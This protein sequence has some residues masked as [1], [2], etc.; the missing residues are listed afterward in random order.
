MNNIVPSSKNL[1]MAAALAL[2]LA[3]AAF[4]QS[5]NVAVPNPAD[6]KAAG[7]LG[8]NYVTTG[9]SYT[10]LDNTGTHVSDFTLTLNENLRD[11][12]DGIVE[13]GYGRSSKIAGSRITQHDILFGARAF[14]TSGAT[15]PYVEAGVGWVWQ[16]GFGSSDDSFA[17]G[18]GVGAE[19][20]IAP[21]ATLTPFVR[22]EDITRGS[23]NDSWTYGLKANYWVSSRVG[24]QAGIARDDDKNMNYSVGA[25]FRF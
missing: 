14:L 10:D 16:K 15:K 20:Q 13:Y 1:I 4:A 19:I 12:I 7:L 3:S 23:N 11:G 8:V 21:A 2:G 18:L 25:N 17:Y 6:N 5:A 22:Y 9:Y 24:L